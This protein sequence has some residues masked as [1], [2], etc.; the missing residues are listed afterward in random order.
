M[1]N[2]AINLNKGVYELNTRVFAMNLR[3]RK[4]TIMFWMINHSI[5]IYGM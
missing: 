4:K 5:E 3:D 2:K 1:L